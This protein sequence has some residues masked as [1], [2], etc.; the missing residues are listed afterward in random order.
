MQYRYRLCI[1]L[2]LLFC[3]SFLVAHAEVDGFSIDLPDSISVG[4]NETIAV[5]YTAPTSSQYSSVTLTCSDPT[6][7]RQYRYDYNTGSGKEPRFGITMTQKGDF[8]LHFL[9][10]GEAFK[11]VQVSV[12]DLAAVQADQRLYVVPLGGSVPFSYTWSGGTLYNKD[13]LRISSRAASTNAEKTLLYGTQS[14][15][16]SATINVNGSLILDTFHI[17]VVDPAENIHIATEYDTVCVGGTLSLHVYSQSGKEV[18]ANI[19]ITEGAELARL[20]RADERTWCELAPVETG[21][22]TITAYGTDGSSDS[23]RIRI[24]KAP[25]SI[26]INIPKTSI[27]A[28]EPF[29][30]VVTMEPADAW[31]PIQVYLSSN[32][33]QPADSGLQ[34][35]VAVLQDDVLTGVLPGTVDLVVHALKDYSFPIT[36]ADSPKALVFERPRDAFDYLKPYQMSVHEQG[37]NAC[38]ANYTLSGSYMTV[39]SDGLLEATNLGFGYITVTLENGLQYK[40][41][42][43]A[44]K[45]PSQMWLDEETLSI[46]LNESKS[47]YTVRSDAGDLSYGDWMLCSNDETVVVCSG[48]TVIPVS[49]GSTSIT[50]WSRYC[51]VSCEVPVTVTAPSSALYIDGLDVGSLDVPIDSTPVSLPTVTD[52]YGNPV[53]VTWEKIHDTPGSGNPK[54]YSVTLNKSKGT[55]TANWRDGAGAELQATSASGDTIRVYIFPYIRSKAAS[56]RESE[57]N[58]HVGER[59][60]VDFMP[61]SSTNNATLMPQDVTFTVSGDTDSVNVKD[62]FFSYYTFIGLKPGTVTLTARLWNG[63]T[64]KATIHVTEYAPCATGHD[65]IWRI[66]SEASLTHNGKKEQYCTRCGLVLDVQSIPCTGVLSFSDTEYYISTSGDTQT[67]SLGTSLNGDRK[68]SFTWRSSDETVVRVEAGRITG[69]KAGTA[70]IVVVCGDCEPAVC[71]VHVIDSGSIYVLRLP[72]QLREIGEGAFEGIAATHVVIRSGAVSIGSR[73]FAGCPNLRMVV[74]PDSVTS[75]AA[76]TFDG[77]AHVTISCSSGSYAESFA[78]EHGIPLAP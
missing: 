54:T 50:I 51:D 46:R 21:Y 4:L 23:K 44:V 9:V 45:M 3:C 37:G 43:R 77:S 42:V 60:Q 70:Q 68:Q 74:I 12:D 52:Y 78:V 32:S 71:E 64:C 30:V 56:F 49:I 33:H 35:Q 39:T 55:V 53:K 25:E 5:A 66:T 38:S 31:C 75:I 27:P 63:K 67:V 69:L 61:D 15:Y 13:G 14:G 41:T 36:V 34:G 1:L 47:I 57:Y 40:Y 26:S 10:N 8:V 11:D 65:P 59:I 6:A 76:D 48:Q 16:Y 73:A 17:L 28:G 7:M 19:E 29:P 18:C 24:S 20:N 58:I 22:V 2:V 72:G 62:A